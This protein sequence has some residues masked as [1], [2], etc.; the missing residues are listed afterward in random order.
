VLLRDKSQAHTG[1]AIINH[2]P[3]IHIKPRPPD[4]ATNFV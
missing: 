4:L 3:P 1:A 2:L